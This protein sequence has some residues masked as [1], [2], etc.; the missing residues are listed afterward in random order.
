MD[1]VE[2]DK[3]DRLLL[4]QKI[5]NEGMKVR[6]KN[7]P[8]G[9]W[10]EG[11]VGQEFEVQ[12]WSDTYEGWFVTGVDKYV[13]RVI[14]ADDCE[15]I[16]TEGEKFDLYMQ[17]GKIVGVRE[18][19]KFKADNLNTVQI[20]QYPVDHSHG[21]VRNSFGES[22]S[23]T[24]ELKTDPV[25]DAVVTKFHQ[26]SQVG[27]KKYGKTLERDDLSFTDWVN[28]AMEEAM[29]FI[30]YLQKLKQEYEKQI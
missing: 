24:D 27:I 12:G 26:R 11:M 9:H 15:I 7:A 10:Y 16:L 8:A 29:D 28:H 2:L 3:M 1:T 22:I 21:Y 25:V 5:K 4:N 30:L 18:K 6:I 17:A 19:N 14:Y 13:G 20:Y 23:R